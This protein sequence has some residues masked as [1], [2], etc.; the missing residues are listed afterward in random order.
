MKSSRSKLLHEVAGHS[1][2][3]YAIRT[4]TIRTGAGRGG[5][6]HRRDQVEAHLAEIAPHVTTAV[7]EEQRGTGHAVQ[8]ALGA[9]GDLDGEV[10]VTYG[11]VP[12]LTGRPWPSCCRAPPPAGRG[13]RAHRPGAGPDRDTGG[14]CA[15]PTTWSRRSSSTGTPTTTSG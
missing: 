1:L 12:M 14:S 9:L 5:G 4:A 11:D 8:V 15:T 3:S 6:G 7:Q 2:L 13:H 10:V